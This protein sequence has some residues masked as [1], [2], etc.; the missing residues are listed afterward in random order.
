MKYDTFYTKYS[1]Y[2][3]TLLSTHAQVINKYFKNANMRYNLLTESV[4]GASCEIGSPSFFLNFRVPG[5][6]AI[7]DKKGLD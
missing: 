7:E 4:S 3:F 5:M 2:I 1:Y 6:L